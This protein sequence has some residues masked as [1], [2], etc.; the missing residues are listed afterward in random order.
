MSG[1]Q[2]HDGDGDAD[3]GYVH[4]RVRDVDDLYYAYGDSHD[5]ANGYGDSS[6]FNVFIFLNYRRL[7]QL[8]FGMKHTANA[9]ILDD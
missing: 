6:L 3:C 7:A 4:A 2:L 9:I 1:D 8:Y 5:D